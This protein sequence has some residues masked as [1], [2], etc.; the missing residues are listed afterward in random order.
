MLC[1]TVDE[2][3]ERANCTKYGLAAG[4][5]MESLD[6]ASR[7]SRSCGSTA[8]TPWTRTRPSGSG[9]GR[10]MGVAAIDKY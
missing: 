6:V 7:M 4:I 5:V 8:T 9:F 3:I 2:A 1:R 10:D